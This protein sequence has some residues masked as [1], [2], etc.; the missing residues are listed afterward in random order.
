MSPF[1][2]IARAISL[3]HLLDAVNKSFPARRFDVVIQDGA[4]GHSPPATT[5]TML[6]YIVTAPCPD[7]LFS[8]SESLGPE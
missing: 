7:G 3:T 5:D 6:K 2:T 1:A 8:G 4:I